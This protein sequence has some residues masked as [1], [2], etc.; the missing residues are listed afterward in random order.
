MKRNLCIYFAALTAF[1]TIISLSCKK[2]H[3]KSRSELLVGS[4]T[5]TSDVFNP[6]Y[7]FNGN[8]TPV[9][10][11]YSTYQA[12]SKDNFTTFNANNT[13]AF[14]EGATKCNPGDQQG[15]SFSWQLSDNDS[16]IIM[17]EYA[18]DA[19]TILQ[20]DNSTLKVST[21]FEESG[22]TYTDTQTFKRK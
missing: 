2:N 17:D 12:C 9:T 13:G 7:D 8:G 14:D 3:D 20:L 19:A 11:A 22:T 16:K 4:W 1:C 5:I 6:A 18:D 21:T 15:Y 10:D